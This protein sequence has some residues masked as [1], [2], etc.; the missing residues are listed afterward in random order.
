GMYDELLKKIHEHFPGA[1]YDPDTIRGAKLDT[2]GYSSQ[3]E[4]RDQ[5]YSLDSGSEYIHKLP[6]PR[7]SSLVES[8]RENLTSD[9]L[10]PGI[11]SG[12]NPL[13]GHCYVASEAYYHMMGGAAS[14]LKPKRM[15]I[16]N[17]VH[18]WLEDKDGNVI[19]ITHDQFP[20][21]VPYD[22][23]RGGGFLTSQPSKR[24]Q[25]LIDR[26]TQ[27]SSRWKFR[28]SLWK[29]AAKWTLEFLPVLPGKQPPQE[30]AKEVKFLADP[31]RYYIYY[32]YVMDH[33]AQPWHDD[34]L[35]YLMKDD[36]DYSI[37]DNL[38]HGYWGNQ[39]GFNM[40]EADL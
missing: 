4:R 39:W 17:D 16:G 32:W 23:G 26:L 29:K 21:P 12:A 19:D 40:Y 28:Y 31:Q 24:A 18:W 5:N 15:R 8:I 38:R 36:D 20:T 25:I 2:E 34:A 7:Y 35:R 11:E 30:E 27:K 33:D 10:K 9:L 13:Q 3:I 37:L 6:N 1:E 22:Q 14:G